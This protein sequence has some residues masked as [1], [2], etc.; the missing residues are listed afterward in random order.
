MVNIHSTEIVLEFESFMILLFFTWLTVVTMCVML[1]TS[2]ILYDRLENMNTDPSRFESEEICASLYTRIHHAK[3]KL[4]PVKKLE[5]TI[6]ENTQ[7][8]NSNKPVIS[9]LR[10]KLLGIK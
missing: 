10:K 1:L 6:Q 2:L 4:Q 8:E 5:K 3:Q 7:E 9:D